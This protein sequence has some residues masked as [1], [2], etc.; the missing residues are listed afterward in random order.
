MLVSSQT[1]NQTRIRF[2]VYGLRSE[3]PAACPSETRISHG[4]QLFSGSA[5][6]L[7]VFP[8]LYSSAI[9]AHFPCL[10]KKTQLKCQPKL[11]QCVVIASVPF[12]FYIPLTFSP[13]LCLYLSI[14]LSLSN[15]KNFCA[16]FITLLLASRPPQAE[17][18]HGDSISHVKGHNKLA[19]PSLLSRQVDPLNDS[20]SGKNAWGKWVETGEDLA[21]RRQRHLLLHSFS[22]FSCGNCWQ[23]MGQDYHDIYI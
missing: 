7:F 3:Q 22:L 21:W 23:L 4:R 13:S 15:G 19:V 5:R 20:F 12:V 18:H 8:S 11:L 2:T 16:A 6:C 10:E 17:A 14:R 1:L 9:V